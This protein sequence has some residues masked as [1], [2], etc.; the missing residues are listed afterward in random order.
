MSFDNI[1]VDFDWTL[2]DPETRRQINEGYQNFWMNTELA[3][4]DGE[5]VRT[6]IPRKKPLTAYDFNYERKRYIVKRDSETD[7]YDWS[8]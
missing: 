6:D 5:V 1:Y 2:F 3:Y 4:V 7:A 8:G